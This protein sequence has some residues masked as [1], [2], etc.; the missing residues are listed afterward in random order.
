[1]IK[2]S[3]LVVIRS[4]SDICSFTAVARSWECLLWSGLGNV[5]CGQVLGMSAVVRSWEC[6][7]W[8]PSVENV[9]PPTTYLFLYR[10]HSH[11]VVYFH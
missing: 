4:C 1:M 5:C 9:V 10:C 8:S 3:F 11:L 6:L 7:L 2:F